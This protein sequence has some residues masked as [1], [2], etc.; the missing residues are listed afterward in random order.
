MKQST[1]STKRP[2]APATRYVSAG[3]P[4]VPSGRVANRPVMDWTAQ[5]TPCSW[6]RTTN[7]LVSFTGPAFSF[8]NWYGLSLLPPFTYAAGPGITYGGQPV[9]SAVAWIA[10]P[11]YEKNTSVHIS[12]EYDLYIT[13]MWCS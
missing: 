10:N 11:W 7:V 8:A 6:G 1:G 4:A 5:S 9:N 13:D 2:L 3:P 12:A